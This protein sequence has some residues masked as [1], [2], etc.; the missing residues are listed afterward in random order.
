MTQPMNRNAK[1]PAIGDVA[2]EDGE[3][4]VDNPFLMPEKGENL[5][6]FERNRMYLNHG[7]ETFVEASALS[8]ADINSDS[9]GAMA[10]DFD[11]D[12]RP[13][14][15]VSSIGGGPLRL[16][17][18]RFDDDN[19]RVTIELRGTKTNAL[20]IGARVMIEC[21][22][23]KIFRDMFPANGFMGME[24]TE[25]VIGLG[26]VEKIDHMNI[27]WPSGEV[28]DFHDLPVNKR[29]TVTEGETLPR[30]GPYAPSAETDKP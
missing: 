28:S 7:G 22:D 30:V 19:A 23:Q 18:N 25:L 1:I 3:F 16:F 4:W 8:A 2:E 24:P 9:R 27:R 6:A 17:L 10:A 15:L 12:G 14:L 11:R 5:S 21:G 13:D 29:I 20:G 26:P